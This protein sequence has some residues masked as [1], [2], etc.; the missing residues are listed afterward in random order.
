M[1]GRP[2]FLIVGLAALVCEIGLFVGVGALAWRLAG[3]AGVAVGVAAVIGA[4]AVAV[5]LWAL[6]MA[7]TA[8]RRLPVWPRATVAGLA[9]LAVGAGLLASGARGAGVALVAAGPL[10]FAAQVVIDDT[11]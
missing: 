8:D 1:V 2:A 6:V 7:P 9:C 11:R 4:L 10:L 3:T 5:A